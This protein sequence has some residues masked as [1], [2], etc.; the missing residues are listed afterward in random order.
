MLWQKLVAATSAAVPVLTFGGGAT[1]STTQSTTTFS[2]IGI[3]TANAN[4]RVIVCILT[5]IAANF[6]S[7]PVVTVAGQSTT[8][9]AVTGP[10]ANPSVRLH[11]YITNAPVT[12]GS[13]ANVVVTAASGQSF[14]RVYLS[15]YAITKAGTLTLGQADV[16][17]AATNPSTQTSALS[18]G[19]VGLFLAAGSTTSGLSDHTV[20]GPITTNYSTGIVNFGSLITATLTGTGTCT[21]TTTGSGSSTRTVLVTWS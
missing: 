4:R 13:T 5:R 14:T 20:S 12:S 2:S 11:V 3:G 16:S 9:V 1:S 15:T 7:N 10:T 6:V 19:Q 17:S 18:S 8:L 21:S